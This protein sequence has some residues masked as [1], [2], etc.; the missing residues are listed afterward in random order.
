MKIEKSDDNLK[1]AKIWVDGIETEHD[2]F[3]RMCHKRGVN[4]ARALRYA[5]VKAVI[6]NE[7][8]VYAQPNQ[9][10]TGTIPEPSGLSPIKLE[11]TDE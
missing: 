7:S 4:G 5:A 11:K 9:D 1:P 3:H 6:T 2:Q 10:P 8:T